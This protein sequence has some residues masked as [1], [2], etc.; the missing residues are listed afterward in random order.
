MTES[1]FMI[2]IEP[3]ETF[4][5]YLK[6][7]SKKA[8]K[9]YVYAYKHNRDLAY[10][11]VPFVRDRVSFFMSLW[12]R[13][14][15]RGQYRQWAF[16][17]EHIEELFGQGRLKVFECFLGDQPVSLQFIQHHQG[18]W[19]CHPPLYD[20][21]FGM[22]RYLAKFMWFKLVEYAILNK[23]E[24]LNMGGGLDESWREMIRRRQ[25]FPN[26]AYKWMYV[27]EA[28]KK[29]P[30]KAKDYQIKELNGKKYLYDRSRENNQHIA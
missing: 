16:P 18:F 12:E 28:I 30:E 23:L 2:I 27:A 26:P 4:E 19:E 17:V 25:E 8:R 7:L 15:I 13:Q 11:P 29:N 14:L 1:D 3:P 21:G 9:N 22:E 20:K 24:P 6:S 10:Q 5:M